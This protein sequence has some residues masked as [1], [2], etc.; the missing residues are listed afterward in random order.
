MAAARLQ[1]DRERTE[2]DRRERETKRAL[3]ETNA[4]LTNGKGAF[5]TKDWVC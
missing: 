4:K 1:W 2:S 5:D 3:E